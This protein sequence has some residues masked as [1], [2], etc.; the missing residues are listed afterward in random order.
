MGS[1]QVR[2]KSSDFALPTQWDFTQ[3]AHG[4]CLS[5]PFYLRAVDVSRK[6]F[7]KHKATAIKEENFD[8]AEGAQVLV[9]FPRRIWNKLGFGNKG[10]FSGVC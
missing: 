7:S 3:G 8:F 1:P 2:A 10:S 6:A 4:F 5:F 9:Y